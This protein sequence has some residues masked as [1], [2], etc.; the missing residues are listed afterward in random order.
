M[1]HIDRTTTLFVVEIA[2]HDQNC[3]TERKGFD[4]V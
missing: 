2:M 1:I 3:G 4:F